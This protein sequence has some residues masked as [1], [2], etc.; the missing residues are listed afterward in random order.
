MYTRIKTAQEIEDMRKSGKILAE[1]HKKLIKEVTP[2][3]STG[4]LAEIAEKEIK[5]LGGYPAFLGYGHPIPFPS[6]VCISVND[7]VVHGIPSN[8]KILKN[9]DIVS[10]DLGVSYNGMITDSAVSVICGNAEGKVQDFLEHT[11]KSLN[12]GLKQI[13]SGCQVGD[14]GYAIQKYLESKNYGVVR[15]LVGHG[16]G[17]EV[18]EDPNIPN[19]GKKRTGPKLVS[20]MTL[21]IEPMA[22]MGNHGVHIKGDGWT[23][24]TND[25]SLAAHFEH[26]ILVTDK[27]CEILTN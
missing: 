24:A 14:V 7:E 25:G 10:L 6:V 4:D 16:V 26:T 20:G 1:V 13:K 3:I 17:H 27:G 19:F 23:V 11:K 2:G 22:T 12:I 15:D 5:K 18:H 8:Q 21:A 9:G